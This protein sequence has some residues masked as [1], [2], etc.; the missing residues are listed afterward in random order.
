MIQA[1]VV[2]PLNSLHL[3]WLPIFDG[4]ISDSNRLVPSRSLHLPVIS[5]RLQPRFCF[6]SCQTWVFMT[7]PKLPPPPPSFASSTNTRYSCQITFILDYKHWRILNPAHP[8][9]RRQPQASASTSQQTT[10]LLYRLKVDAPPN[11]LCGHQ[12]GPLPQSKGT[13]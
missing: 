13:L 3:K 2:T 6:T 4:T 7:H 11:R 10:G 5:G 12:G 9:E 1:I 8:L